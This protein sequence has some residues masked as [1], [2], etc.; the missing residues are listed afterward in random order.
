MQIQANKGHEDLNSAQIKSYETGAL[1]SALIR[2]K[3]Y[4]FIEKINR[5]VANIKIFLRS[6]DKLLR[7]VTELLK[8]LFSDLT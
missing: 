6:D 4:F 1:N 5:T 2:I 7:N 3:L 8:I